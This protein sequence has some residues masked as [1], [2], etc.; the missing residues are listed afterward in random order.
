[1]DSDLIPPGKDKCECL[2]IAFIAHHSTLFRVQKLWE[3]HNA[4]G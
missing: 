1:M 3:L 2:N 4:E